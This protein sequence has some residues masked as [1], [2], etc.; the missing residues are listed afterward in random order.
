MVRSP[1][2]NLS[3]DESLD[4]YKGKVKVEARELNASCMITAQIDDIFATTQVKVTRKESGPGLKIRLVDESFGSW[5]AINEKEELP[6][7]EELLVIK[8]AGRHPSIRPFLSETSVGQNHPVVRSIISE[9]VA[10]VASRI[11]VQELYQIRRTTEDFD[12]DRI[13][14]EHNKRIKRFLPRFHRILI[15]DPNKL[16]ESLLEPVSLIETY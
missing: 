14:T 11:V 13:Y 1:T 9:A 8:I 12:A 4:F 7:G 5:R 6:T 15:G 2:L 3:Y 10:D 16:S